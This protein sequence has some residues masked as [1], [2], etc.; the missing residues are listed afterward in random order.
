M[1][2]IKLTKEQKDFLIKAKESNK[3]NYQ[4]NTKR[5]YNWNYSLDVKDPS[6]SGGSW[7]GL[8]V[9]DWI[10]IVIDRN[11]YSDYAD[12]DFLNSV[13]TFFKEYDKI[14]KINDYI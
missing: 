14:I 8:R 5:F 10:Q 3:L 7:G 4:H 6:M 1:N 11:T 13:G 12:A 9:K 2:K